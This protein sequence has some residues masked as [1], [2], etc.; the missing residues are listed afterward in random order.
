M[1]QKELKHYRLAMD[2]IDGKLTIV[3]FAIQIN[4]S[5]R[6]AQRIVKKIKEKGSLGSLHGNANRVPHNKTSADLEIKIVDLL[7]YKY[8]N[9]NLTHFKEK[10]EKLENIRIKKD[11]L[12]TIAKKHGL[13][14][15]PK[16]RGRRCHKPRPRLAK[17][18]MMIQFDGSDHVW[19][20]EGRTDLIGGIDDATGTVVAAEFFYGETS[21]HSLKVIREIVD[22]Y[23][24]PESFYMDQASMYGK[25]DKEWESQ[26]SRAF[27]QTGIQLILAGSSQAK[28]RIER[29]WRTFQDRLVTELE[30]YNIVE[31]DEANTFLKETFIP[32][33]NL[34][35]SV[36][37]QEPE[38]AYRK[39]VFGNLDII[40]CKKI[41]R[42][43]MV[44]N[45]FSWDNVTWVIDE[46]KCYYG[47]ELNVNIHL[48]GSYSFDIMGRKVQCKI[49]NRKRLSDYG[50]KS[51]L[52]KSA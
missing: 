36:E 18:G 42:K 40:F 45:V 31:F 44:G 38:T 51:K 30:F 19:F 48:D 22:N 33:F 37:A 10:I 4:K 24:I 6:Q 13:V 11:A 17:E 8:K 27:D 3:D 47:R 41:R 50:N 5:Y 52:R 49:S 12:H 23:G 25:K 39:N 7:K 14:K 35:F 26:I 32:E 43:I 1:S 20:G 9:F 16:R 21:N 46:K 2:V 29:L 28:G 15:H 34:Q